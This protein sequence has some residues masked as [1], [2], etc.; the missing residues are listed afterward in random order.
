MDEILTE[1]HFA[2]AGWQKIATE[3]GIP[4]SEQTLMA[5]AFKL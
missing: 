5:A 3:T 4:H 2:I 1:V